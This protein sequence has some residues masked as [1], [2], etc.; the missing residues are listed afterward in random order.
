M[1]IA[2]KTGLGFGSAPVV[3]LLGYILLRTFKVYSKSENILIQAA[4]SGGYLSMFAIDSAVA[5]GVIYLKASLSVGMIF[6]ISLLATISGIV[7]GYFLG[8]LYINNEKLPFPGGISV[9]ETINSLEGTSNQGSKNL[10]I[11]IIVALLINVPIQLFNWLPSSLPG[12][13]FMNFPTFLGLG[14]STLVFGLG[15]MISWRASLT[16]LIGSL[17][18]YLVWLFDEGASNSIT[19]GQHANNIWILSIG[20]SIIVMSALLSL[21]GIKSIFLKIFKQI[22]G[23]VRKKTSVGQTRHFANVLLVL[24]LILTFLLFYRL[25]P[26]FQSILTVAFALLPMSLVAVLFSCRSS[27]ETGIAPI[28][29]LGIIT[30][31]LAAL[32]SKNFQL[33]IFTGAFVCAT[34]LAA[35]TMINSLKAASLLETPRDELLKAQ[36]TGG[37]FGVLVGSLTIYVIGNIYIFG[38]ENLPAP[39][40]VA[41][42]TLVET[43]AKGQIPHNV[44]IPLG[45]AGAMAAVILTKLKLSAICFGIGIII[46]PSY[47]LTLFLGGMYRYIIEKKYQENKRVLLTKLNEG[48]SLMSGLIVG[49]GLVAL[50]S[51]LL[52]LFH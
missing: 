6:G 38:S 37:I 4:A 15:Y 20:T 45:V 11:G 41:W 18:S 46:P 52:N 42:G 50:I 49:E 28:T 44:S 47:S 25:Y 14:L 7:L 10:V 17:V 51:F 24:S 31:C 9:A 32:F 36:L 8:D 23:Q 30:F 26:T 3:A 5:A 16:V 2:L 21:S 48:Q 40:S 35:T 1:I 19:Y 13:L 33:I 43:I 12:S 22:G 34:G 29:P 39:V 27:G